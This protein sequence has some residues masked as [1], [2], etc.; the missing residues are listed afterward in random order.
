MTKH[1][2]ITVLSE[3]VRVQRVAKEDFIS[4]TDIAKFKN[5]DDPR[6]IIQNWMRTRFSIEFLG[7]WETLNNPN[8]N[9]VEFDTVKNEAGT[10]AFVMT[11]SKWVELTGAIGIQ[12]KAGR[13]GGTYAHRDIAFEFASWVSVEF[14]L[15]LIKEFQRLQA[16]EAQ[17]LGWDVKRNLTKINYQIHTD[18][19]QTHLIPPELSGPQ[20]R[21]IYASEA[22]VL[23]MALFGQTA[24][25]WR[26]ANPGDKGNIRDQA[27]AS[28]LVCLANLENLNALFINEGTEQPDRLKKLNLIAIEQMEILTS[29]RNLK[30]LEGGKG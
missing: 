22:D 27:N 11:P 23:N 19:I 25:Q 20:V 28:Q 15:Y 29:D 7:I 9:R 30:R 3:T 14:K 5:S 1:K 6:F 12:S 18:A 17:Q 21:R 2:E 4:L 8:F 16:V 13:Y 26:D 10:N 24:K